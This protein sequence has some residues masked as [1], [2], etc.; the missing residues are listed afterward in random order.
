MFE[1]FHGRSIVSGKLR[2]VFRQPMRFTRVKGSEIDF[3]RSEYEKANFNDFCDSSIDS[4]LE[5]N[6]KESQRVRPRVCA[7]V[8]CIN[9]NH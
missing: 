9:N 7:R 1:S 2:S 6:E 3:E 5:L 4:T 8:P